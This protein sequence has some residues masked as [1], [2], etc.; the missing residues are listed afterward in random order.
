MEEPEKLLVDRGTAKELWKK[1]REWDRKPDEFNHGFSTGIRYAIRRLG[2][3]GE[4]ES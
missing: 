3:D 4:A 1:S 2:I